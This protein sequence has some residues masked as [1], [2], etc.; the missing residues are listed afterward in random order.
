MPD[1]HHQQILDHMLDEEELKAEE[2][3]DFIINGSQA[4]GGKKRSENMM[5][6]WRLWSIMRTPTIMLM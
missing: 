2:M 6:L 1:D 5:R 3:F 4:E